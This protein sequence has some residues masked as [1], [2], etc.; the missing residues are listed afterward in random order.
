MLTL[1]SRN[2]SIC[3]CPA[4]QKPLSYK[5]AN[6]PPMRICVIK[7]LCLEI[8]LRPRYQFLLEN[9]VKSKLRNVR[10][11]AARCCPAAAERAVCGDDF[12]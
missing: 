6:S 11:R 2:V 1:S 4:L 3:I 7:L 9:A 5:K 10:S 8:F 12:V